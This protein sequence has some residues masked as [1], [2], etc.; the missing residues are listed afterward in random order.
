MLQVV[1]SHV[2]YEIGRKCWGMKSGKWRMENGKWNLPKL[3][4]IS[5]RVYCHCRKIPN[6]NP[7]LIPI[8]IP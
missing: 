1:T 2:A 4:S 5:A 7:K 3:I 6:P 8:S